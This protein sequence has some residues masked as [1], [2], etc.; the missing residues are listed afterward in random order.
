MIAEVVASME[1]GRAAEAEV[2]EAIRKLQTA[3]ER[4]PTFRGLSE[5]LADLVALR[6]LY[7]KLGAE[8][9]ILGD[10][11]DAILPA[12]LGRL[13]ERL[14]FFANLA[15][16]GGNMASPPVRLIGSVCLSI[17]PSSDLY[18]GEGDLFLGRFQ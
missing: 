10:V 8:P 3:C 14:R 13:T 15:K 4:D 17:S 5:R 16:L 7:L 6:E 9:A 1:A 2:A 18:L 11:I 12:V